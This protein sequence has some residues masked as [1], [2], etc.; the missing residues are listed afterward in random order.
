MVLRRCILQSFVNHL[1]ESLICAVLSSNFTLI[2][3]I[4]VIDMSCNNQFITRP[5]LNGDL[6][7]KNVDVLVVE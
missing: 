5:L 1:F 7:A 2:L 3:L 4:T 6:E